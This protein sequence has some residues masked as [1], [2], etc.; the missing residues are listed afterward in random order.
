MQTTQ[1]LSRAAEDGRRL[2]VGGSLLS[3]VTL[4]AFLAGTRPPF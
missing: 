2:R 4:A 3:L 1:K